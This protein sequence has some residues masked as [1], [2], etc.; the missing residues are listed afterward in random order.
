MDKKQ[1]ETKGILS[2]MY[3][4]FVQVPHSWYKLCRKY[5]VPEEMKSLTDGGRGVV[6]LNLAEINVLAYLGNFTECYPTNNMIAAIFKVQKHTIEKYI[7]EL[8]VVGFIKTY[9]TKDNP[10]HTKR[11]TIYVQHDVIQEVLKSEAD[12]YIIPHEQRVSHECEVSHE[13]DASTSQTECRYPTNVTLVPHKCET[14]KKVLERIRKNKKETASPIKEDSSINT[15]TEQPIK[16]KDLSELD[17]YTV[18]RGV[19]KH[20]TDFLLLADQYNKD[21]FSITAEQVKNVYYD[22][23]ENL[24]FA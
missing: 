24:P 14:N 6:N 22:Y 1:S 19:E 20:G 16:K 10:T 8:R 21:G 2:K 23:L 18:Y 5:V 11:R 13:C 7:K 17:G 3:G 4:E 15:P 12:P 9:E